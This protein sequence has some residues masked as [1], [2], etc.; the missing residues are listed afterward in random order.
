MPSAEEE[1]ID[2]NLK[3][4]PW[5]FP[6]T[7][8]FTMAILA[9]YFISPMLLIKITNINVPDMEP[10]MLELKKDPFFICMAMIFSSLLA[11]YYM[12]F[13]AKLRSLSLKEYLGF[14]NTKLIN[15]IF[16]V[17]G[18]F[19][20]LMFLG[21]LLK[22]SNFQMPKSMTDLYR[23][24]N[25]PLLLIATAVATPIYEEFLYRGFMLKGIQA[26][27]GANVAIIYSSIIFA[28]THFQYN[29]AGILFVFMIGLL[30]GFA[31]IKTN[32]IYIPITMHCSLNAIVCFS[33]T[34]R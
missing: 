3:S 9:I 1:V 33:H 32:S 11:I 19:V 15:G 2:S 10:R 30:L 6:E 12:F 13:L 24:S 27:S 31:K 5:G 14:N 28:V 18:F 34:A 4:G 21:A 16:W 25:V 20:I 22:L 8:G 7:I 17:F 23:Y 26:T 29:L